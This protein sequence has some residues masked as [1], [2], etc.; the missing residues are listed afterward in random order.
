V[1]QE[2]DETVL[3]AM[4]EKSR[5][6]TKW[7]AFENHA[8]DSSLRGHLQFVMFGEGCTYTTRPEKM[9][10]TAFDTGWKYVFVGIVNLET[11]EIEKESDAAA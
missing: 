3:H 2:I 1:T 7:A 5:H 11:G 8:L 4:R 10:D 6:N 9:P